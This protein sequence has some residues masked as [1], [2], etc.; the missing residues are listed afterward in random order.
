MAKQQKYSN[1]EICYLVIQDEDGL[2]VPV[3]EEIHIDISMAFDDSDF[4]S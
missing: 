1:R 4:F 2:Q 3:K